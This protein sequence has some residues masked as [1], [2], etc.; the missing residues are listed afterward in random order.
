MCN[1]NQDTI[2]SNNAISATTTDKTHPAEDAILQESTDEHDTQS[3]MELL[4]TDS[5]VEG[6]IQ[7]GSQTPQYEAFLQSLS[8]NISSYL[9]ELPKET[10]PIGDAPKATSSRSERLSRTQ[11]KRSKRTKRAK[12]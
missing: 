12:P 3:D 7:I 8:N 2:N 9:L 11:R 4:R 10:K 1:Q 6:S 5:L